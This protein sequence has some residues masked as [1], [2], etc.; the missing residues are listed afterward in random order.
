MTDAEKAAYYLLPP[1]EQMGIELQFLADLAETC[2]L[3]RE[4]QPIVSSDSID[5]I[6]ADYQLVE[7][8][9]NHDGDEKVMW[10]NSH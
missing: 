6:V 4:P 1:E 9:L 7:V 2:P 10:D 5:Y 8:L 3:P